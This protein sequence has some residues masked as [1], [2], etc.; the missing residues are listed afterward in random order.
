MSDSDE[1]S[2]SYGLLSSKASSK[3]KREIEREIEDKEYLPVILKRNDESTRHPDDVLERAIAEGLEQH[4]R[5]AASLYLSAI[6]AGLILG[7]AG[8]CVALVAQIFHESDNLLYERISMALVYPLGF[9]ICIMSGTQ[10]FTEQTATA[11]YPFLDREV[12]FRSL[13][14]LWVIVLLGNFTGTFLSSILIYLSDDV[15]QA[16]A[17]FIDIYKHIIDYSFLDI[18]ISAILAGWLMAQGGWL[19]L[20]TPPTSSQIVCIYIVTFVI[21]LGGL[22]HSIAGSAE[23]FTGMF[24]SGD[25]DVAGIMKFLTSSVLGNLIGGSVFVGILNYAHIR[26]T[27]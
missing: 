16:S 11:V 5:S 27:R 13:V 8:M 26:K 20:A 10:L 14:M 7:F 4:K 24:H 9:I 1:Y 18:F 3:N 25:Y 19:I 22:H 2:K 21:G 17:G 12:K 23:V 15:I 6:S